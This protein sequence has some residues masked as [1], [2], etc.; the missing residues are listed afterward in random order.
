MRREL[1][2]VGVLV[3]LAMIESADANGKLMPN[4]FAERVTFSVAT[5]AAAPAPNT[6]V[7][8]DSLP[9][10][11]IV[12]GGGGVPGFVERTVARL[13]VEGEL[14]SETVVAERE[15]PAI[16][17]SKRIS[18]IGFDVP[19]KQLTLARTMTVESTAYTPDA[20]LGSRATFRT[21]TG[22]RAEFGVI[23]V[24]PRVIPLN[25]LVFVEGYGLA[26]ACDTGGAIKGNKIDV[27]VTT[28]RTARI[29]GRRNVRIHVFKERITR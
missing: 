25:T 13:W 28:N 4:V 15:I 22:R 16:P 5:Q 9:V 1:T 27:C 6:Y 21:A 10:G 7:L 12:D 29:W 18:S 3:A 11:K 8:D 23:A 19:H 17:G 14:K 24:D 2:F 20:G 26:L